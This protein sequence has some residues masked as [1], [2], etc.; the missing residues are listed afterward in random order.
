MTVLIVEWCP[1]LLSAITVWQMWLVGN[2]DPAAWVVGYVS[3]A[4]WLLWI[5]TSETY[6]LL[7]LNA[8]LWFVFARN[9]LR[10]SAP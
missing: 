6:G 7:P 8:A 10:W 1:W 9:H 3:Q 4:L 2:H 5:V